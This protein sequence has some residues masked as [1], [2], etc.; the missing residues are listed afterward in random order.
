[1]LPEAEDVE[2]LE[3]VA[4]GMTEFG[5]RRGAFRRFCSRRDF[6]KRRPMRTAASEPELGAA[7]SVGSLL[8]PPADLTELLSTYG[9]AGVSIAVVRPDGAGNASVSTQV[10][11]LAERATGTAMFD[12]TFLQICSL[13][14][15][16]AAVLAVDYFAQHDI[17]LHTSVNILLERAGSPFRFRA[18]EGV[19]ASW[20]DEVTLAHLINHTGPQM[21]YVY[22]IPREHEFPPVLALISGSTERPA[23]YGYATLEVRKRPGTEFG[24]SGGGFLVLQHL[25][26]IREGTPIAE[27]F[28]SHLRACGTVRSPLYLNRSESQTASAERVRFVRFVR[29]ATSAS[30]LR[31]RIQASSTPAAIATTVS[32]CQAAGSSFHL[33]PP[34]RAAQRPDSQI[35]C[36]CSRS[37]TRGPKAVGPSRMPLRGQC[38]RGRQI[39]GRRRS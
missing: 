12:S 15:P 30:P 18:A 21:H 26:E 35:G 7:P 4:F 24:Y 39:L 6:Q 34:G 16:I 5:A 38:W 14:K 29:P 20:A 19:E 23:P 2:V 27:L 36:A 22:G 9:V 11:G 3:E 32:L 8:L 28:A 33:S 13:S 31:T 37:L 17:P 10:A 25:L 1:M